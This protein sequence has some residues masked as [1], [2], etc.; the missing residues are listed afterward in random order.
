MSGARAIFLDR[1]G[2]LNELVGGYP[3][4]DVAGLTLLAGAREACD[5]LRTAGYMLFVVTNQPDVA[6]GTTPRAEAEAI[7]DWL[8]ATLPID[9]TYTCFH[10][11]ESCDCRKPRPRS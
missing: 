4:A 5:T 2:T 3:P 6:R 11:G 8:A 1:D 7:N 9:A 10:D